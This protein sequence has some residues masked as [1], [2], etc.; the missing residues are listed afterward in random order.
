MDPVTRRKVWDTINRVKRGRCVILTTHSMEEAEMLGDRVA[1]MS[2]GKLSCIGSSLHLKNKFGGGFRLSVVVS[3]PVK[4]EQTQEM[5]CDEA[6]GVN[7]SFI[8]KTQGVLLFKLGTHNSSLLSPFFEKIENAKQMLGISDISIGNA[9]LND[10]FINLSV[11]E[12]KSDDKLHPDEDKDTENDENLTCKSKC[13]NC[14]FKPSRYCGDCGDCICC[15]R[16]S[17]PVPS[18][19]TEEEEAARE[20]EKKALLVSAPQ[21]QVYALVQKSLAFQV[22][23]FNCTYLL[24]K[25]LISSSLLR[26]GKRN[27]CVAS[28][29]SLPSS[30]CSSHCSALSYSTQCIANMSTSALLF[31]CY[32]YN[33]Y[34]LF[35]IKR[36]EKALGKYDWECMK[37]QLRET[38][39]LKPAISVGNIS[40]KNEQFEDSDWPPLF[41][42]ETPSF[43]FF[44]T[45]DSDNDVNVVET[46]DITIDDDVVGSISEGVVDVFTWHQKW[47]SKFPDLYKCSKRYES[48]YDKE[49]VYKSN[50]KEDGNDP[51]SVAYAEEWD[52]YGNTSRVLRYGSCKKTTRVKSR[53]LTVPPD[54]SAV[55]K[56]NFLNSNYS[57]CQETQ[58]PIRK[59]DDLNATEIINLQAAQ[60]SGNGVLDHLSFGSVFEQVTVNYIDSIVA[61][62]YA[63]T[64][65]F[66]AC[67]AGGGNSSK[68]CRNLPSS[69]EC[70][71]NYNS[72]ATCDWVPSGGPSEGSPSVFVSNMAT[73]FCNASML[74]VNSTLRVS[75]ASA[76]AGGGG[77]DFDDDSQGDDRVDG[78]CAW[79][80]NIDAVRGVRGDRVGTSRKQLDKKLYKDWFGDYDQYTDTH[81]TK[82][83]SFHFAE[84]VREQY[85]FYNCCCA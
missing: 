36:T 54:T 75:L 11:A 19:P 44:F 66:Y 42:L 52:T 29:C 8:S 77:G 51:A 26:C 68:D 7:A 49:V 5:I 58:T 71:W 45:S 18:Q 27:S 62:A 47:L 21:G 55:N 60:S 85:V 15:C 38:E 35:V 16:C 22:G 84:A 69:Y 81:R 59:F 40:P 30:L 78:F 14:C 57:Q 63:G 65:Q 32:H 41:Y 67:Y 70:V 23:L 48:K 13:F 46:D 56:L 24:I 72:Q 12:A 17:S 6:H 43:D 50:G 25:K 80:N 10:V 82:F 28:S 74:S 37:D 4:A 83:T 2:G 73:Y 3:D 20:E 53:Q 31:M 61:S 33:C 76:L 34:F 1:V 39:Y 9:T 64:S 79:L